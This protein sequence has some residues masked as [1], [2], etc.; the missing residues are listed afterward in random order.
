MNAIEELTAFTAANAFEAL[1][2]LTPVN[3]IRNAFEALRALTENKCVQVST[4]GME[5]WQDLTPIG[6]KVGQGMWG[7]DIFNSHRL[8]EFY[9]RLK[10]VIGNVP[11]YIMPQPFDRYTVP[12]N[13]WYRDPKYPDSVKRISTFEDK[14]VRFGYAEFMTYEGLLQLGWEYSEDGRTNWNPCQ[15][16]DA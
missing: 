10:P 16:R 5:T 2:S 13:A 4:D 6:A 11:T 3:S 1:R 15:R 14:C 8:N 7:L 12:L 9:F